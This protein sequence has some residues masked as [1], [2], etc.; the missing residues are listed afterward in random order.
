MFR[1]EEMDI[2]MGPQHPSTHGV[3]RLM[4]TLDGEEI[5]D[6]RPIIGYLHRGV[7]KLSEHPTYPMIEPLTDRLDYVAAISENLGYCG[8]VEKLMRLQRPP[9]AQHIRRIPAKRQ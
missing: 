9:R 2:N 5:V 7:E 8:A 4:L 3:L 1:T 6:V